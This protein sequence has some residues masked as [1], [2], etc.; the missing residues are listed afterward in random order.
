M[1]IV[2]EW[3]HFDALAWDQREL[4]LD[5]FRP[6]SKGPVQPA[7]TVKCKRDVKLAERELIYF[8]YTIVDKCAPST[9]DVLLYYYM[10]YLPQSTLS[11]TSMNATTLFTQGPKHIYNCKPALLTYLLRQHCSGV[12]MYTTMAVQVYQDIWRCYLPS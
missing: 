7:C 9:L 10:Y 5:N 12:Y 6:S 4:Y 3:L 1:C 2:I 11:L 8:L